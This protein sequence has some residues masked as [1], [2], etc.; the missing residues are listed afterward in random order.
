MIRPR[1]SA[2]LEDRKALT[3]HLT[4]LRNS[5]LRCIVTFILSLSLCWWGGDVIY[6]ALFGK[7]L[8]LLETAHIEFIA[9]DLMDRFWIPLKLSVSGAI[10]LTAPILL[11]EIQRFLKPGL[12]ENERRLM[13]AVLIAGPV[14]CALG[15]GLWFWL[16]L[17]QTTAFLMTMGPQG[18]KNILSLSQFLS[19]GLSMGLVFGAL[20]ETPLVL[21]ALIKAGVVS[22]A[23]LAKRRKAALVV[24]AFL[25]AVLTPSPDAFTMLVLWAPLV[26]LFEGTL[27]VGRII[28]KPPILKLDPLTE[29][30]HGP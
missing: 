21:L 29:P 27:L 15:A 30:H 16:V 6:K 26:L 25:S 4:D 20:F 3:E 9:I 13:R 24:L 17:P 22:A 1:Q 19:F 12:K 14:L 2:T 10:I 5:I 7:T 8:S 11:F 23:A 18:L 28:E